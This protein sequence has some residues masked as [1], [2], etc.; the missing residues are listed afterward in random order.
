M[1]LFFRKFRAQKCFHAIPNAP[2]SCCVMPSDC[3]T[4]GTLDTLCPIQ[5]F[6]A[7][8]VSQD[9]WRN[10]C[11]DI[12]ISYPL[13]VAEK[14]CLLP[15]FSLFIAP[16]SDKMPRLWP[17]PWLT[18]QPL[19]RRQ[20]RRRITCNGGS[21]ILLSFQMFS[22]LTLGLLFERK[23]PSLCL[24]S[25]PGQQIEEVHSFHFFLLISF[26][27]FSAF[28][29]PCSFLPPPLSPSFISRQR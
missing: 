23:T 2:D 6:I 26:F 20:D 5:R 8:C 28:L 24:P 3:Q 13:F 10:S 14:H 4:N 12:L 7:A 16:Q 15:C 21:K 22:C 9:R 27:Y 29:T 19:A 1:R 17:H 25:L 11:P 18:P